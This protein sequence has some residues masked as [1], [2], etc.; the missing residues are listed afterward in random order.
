MAS[1]PVLARLQRVSRRPVAER[2]PLPS[3]QLR[4]EQQPV[5]ERAAASP[6]RGL[7]RQVQQVQVPLELEQP[8]PRGVSQ[9]RVQ[10]PL[11]LLVLE[12]QGP[13][14]Q[15]PEPPRERPGLT[16]RVQQ[17]GLGPQGP[18][19]E[20]PRRRELL[21][22]LPRQQPQPVLRPQGQQSA[23]RRG[24]QPQP[25]ADLAPLERQPPQS[26]QRHSAAA[27]LHSEERP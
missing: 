3:W 19:E 27:T 18:P 16:P 9:S 5:Q 23:E 14:W 11:A 10:P 7:G 25:V 1:P 8:V 2:Q 20:G 17:P 13:Q 22:A 26:E 6:P 4:Q 15:L 12:R 24:P 21:L